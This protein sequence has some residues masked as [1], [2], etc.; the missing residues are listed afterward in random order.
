MASLRNLAIGILHARGDH[1]I[2]AA[3]GR[4]ARDPPRGPAAAGRHQPMN[5]TLRHATEALRYRLVGP[6][7]RRR[8]IPPP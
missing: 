2:A 6:T 1:N 8:P 5:Q 7:A 3:L 4:S